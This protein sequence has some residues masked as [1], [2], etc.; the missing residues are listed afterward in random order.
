MLAEAIDRVSEA[1]LQEFKR[2]SEVRESEG[3]RRTIENYVF[4]DQRD[5]IE[6]LFSLFRLDPNRKAIASYG[7]FPRHYQSLSVQHG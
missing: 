4:M 3:G 6:D 2:L 5:M 7:M 1:S